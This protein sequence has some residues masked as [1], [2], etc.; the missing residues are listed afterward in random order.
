VLNNLLLIRNRGSTG[1]P[2][3]FLFFFRLAYNHRKNNNTPP[4]K[5]EQIGRHSTKGGGYIVAVEIVNHFR[6][7]LN[8]EKE[9][10]NPIRG[11]IDKSL[12]TYLPPFRL[13]M[14][15][16]SQESRLGHQAEKKRNLNLDRKFLIADS[17]APLASN[18]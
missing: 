2:T 8:K 11:H 7:L 3:F 18:V 12:V 10:K 14:T 17:R 4:S 9:K 6:Q 13:K 1:T 16:Y 15:W 5:Q